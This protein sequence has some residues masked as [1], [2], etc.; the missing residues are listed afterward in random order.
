MTVLNNHREIFLEISRDFMNQSTSDGGAGFNQFNVLTAGG[1]PVPTTENELRNQNGRILFQSDFQSGLDTLNKFHLV[2]NGAAKVPG[3]V[4]ASASGGDGNVFEADFGDGSVSTEI[5]HS[6][7]ADT[8]QWVFQ[9]QTP[10]KL[11]NSDI[12]FAEFTTIL[13]SNTF[14]GVQ[15]RSLVSRKEGVDTVIPQTSWNINTLSGPETPQNPSGITLDSS[16]INSIVFQIPFKDSGDVKVGFIIDNHIVYVHQ[17]FKNNISTKFIPLNKPMRIEGSLVSTDN[18]TLRMGLFDDDSGHFFQ[19]AGTGQ[20]GPSLIS[21][22]YSATCFSVGANSNNYYRTFSKGNETNLK[23]VGATR[24]PLVSLKPKQ[25]FPPATPNVDN[26]TIV[27]L[28]EINVSGTSVNQ[29]YGVFIEV[30]FFQGLISNLLTGST[31]TITDVDSGVDIDTAATAI[32]LLGKQIYAT[33]IFPNQGNISLS[34]KP[35][36]L[37]SNFINQY[38]CSHIKAL[39]GV[40]VSIDPTISIVA[41]SLSANT[42]DL[43]ATLVWAE[44]A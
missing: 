38:T 19:Q 40:D 20:V 33:T 35:E 42:V 14:L 6:G 17:F 21:K 5:D 30:I 27:S 15:A 11:N 1:I 10:M 44:K 29:D 39:G 25:L 16:K 24:I 12:S 43:T 4:N 28:K 41:K 22:F 18:T 8:N 34:V 26:K 37:F 2:Y 36:E 13:V 3:V 7:T 23:T 9:S 31:F 32:T